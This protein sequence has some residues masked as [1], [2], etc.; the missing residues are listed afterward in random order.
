MYGEI[1]KKYCPNCKETVSY[2]TTILYMID[3]IE[4]TDS[5]NCPKCNEDLAK[6]ERA[7]INN[8]RVEGK[9]VIAIMC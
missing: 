8:A 1:L 2:T 3:G 4:Y 6:E 7:F 9:T 5:F